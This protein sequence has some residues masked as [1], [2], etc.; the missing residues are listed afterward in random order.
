VSSGTVQVGDVELAWESFGE[1]RSRPLLLV[2]GLATQ[3]V[4]WHEDFLSMLVEHGL[5]VVRFDNRDIGRSTHLRD[6]PR[7]D[8]LAAVRGD[9][10]SASYALE[11]M[12]DDTAGLLD[13]L[14]LDSAHLLGASM[15]GMIAQTVAVRHPRRVRSL[16]SVMSTPSPRV[17]PPTK[18]ASAVLLGAPARTRDEAVA[19]A[20]RTAQVIGSPG[21][22]LDEE[23]VADVAARSFDRG[24]DPRG[25]GRQLVAIHASGDRTEQLRRICAPTLVVHGEADPLVQVAGGR[26][27]AEAVP[28]AELLIVPGMGHDLPRGVWPQLVEAVLRVVERGEQAWTT[29]SRS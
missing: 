16:T 18:E 25:V 9:A 21:Y 1:E 10:S 24:H 19:L 12:A 23:R 29:S 22:P 4:D 6:A 5:F 8:V 28:G 11:D 14:G 17:G 13:A 27:T 20:L 26:A 3:L 15:G 2:A 7:P